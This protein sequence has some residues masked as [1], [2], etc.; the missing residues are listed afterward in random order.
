MN[1]GGWPWEKYVFASETLKWKRKYWKGENEISI[2]MNNRKEKKKV[3][4]VLTSSISENHH[5]LFATFGDVKLSLNL[6]D[7]KKSWNLHIIPRNIWN[8]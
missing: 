1:E 4:T 2:L 8:I 3:E 6:A 5:G 7:E